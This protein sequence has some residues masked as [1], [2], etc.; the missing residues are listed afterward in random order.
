MKLTDRRVDA[1]ALTDEERGRLPEL[2]ELFE[3]SG[4]CLKAATGEE[5]PL[6][7]PIFRL[8]L[9]IIED[10]RQGRSI[11]LMR[12]DETLTTQSA[13]NFLGMSRQYFVTLIESGKIPFH[14]VGSHRRVL[15]RDLRDFTKT[16][17]KDRRS[18]LD[19]VFE[20][21]EKEGHYKSEYTGGDS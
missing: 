21:I 7:E 9:K 20:T 4:H 18:A 15:L 19:N 13:A 5:I 12:E 2:L 14:K 17:D 3:K 6:P 8:L 10:M 16:R 11:V 1:S